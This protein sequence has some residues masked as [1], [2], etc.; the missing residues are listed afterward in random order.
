L[1]TRLLW[2]KK[3]VGVA[4]DLRRDK[5][6]GKILFISLFGA[7]IGKDCVVGVLLA[8]K[9]GLIDVPEM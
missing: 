5:P 9:N 3:I 2:H 1:S 4:T 8:A 6:V 7:L